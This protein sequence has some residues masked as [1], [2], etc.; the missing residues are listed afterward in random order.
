MAAYAYSASLDQ[1]YSEKTGGNKGLRILTGTVDVT[2]Y[3]TTN[4]AVTEI[5]NQ[6]KHLLDV[7]LSISDNGF[8]GRWTGTSIKVFEATGNAGAAEEAD[9]DDDAG[10][11]QFVAIGT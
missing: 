8:F 7:Q 10:V 1:S 2:N 9:D 11:F 6:F 5:S 4:V 3:N